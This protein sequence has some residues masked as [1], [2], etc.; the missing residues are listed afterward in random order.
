MGNRI[1]E[2]RVAKDWTQDRLARKAR[3]DD[4]TVSYIERGLRRPSPLVR[5]RLARA[6]AVPEDVLFE[7]AS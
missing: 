1:R 4:S 5:A 6:L 7:E 3:I 2:F